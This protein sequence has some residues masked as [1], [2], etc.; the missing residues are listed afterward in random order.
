MD[1]RIWLFVPQ[2]IAMTATLVALPFMVRKLRPSYAVY[3]LVY[4]IVIFSPTWLIS[5]VRYLMALIPLYPLIAHV[6]R[7]K[8]LDIALTVLMAL[9]ALTLATGHALHFH[10]M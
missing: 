3:T 7:H 5:A 6:T 1:T 4:V 9:A 10:V 2:T 8:T